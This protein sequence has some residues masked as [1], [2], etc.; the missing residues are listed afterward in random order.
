[1]LTTS[2]SSAIP[3]QRSLLPGIDVL[4][5]H[6]TFGAGETAVR[7]VDG[8][9]FT[10]EPGEVVALM[11]ASGCGKST[12][13]NIIA[14]LEQADSGKVTVH[15]QEVT[16]MSDKEK[17]ELRLSTVG[18]VFQEN[19]LIEDLTAAENVGL[20]L[21]AAGVPRA[22]I[23]GEVAGSRGLVGLDSLAGRFPREMSGGQ[24]Q[25]V[26]IARAITGGRSVLLADEPTGALDSANSQSVFE[27]LGQLAEA[28]LTVLVVTHD[29]LVAPHSTRTLYMRDGRL[30]DGPA[31]K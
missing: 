14:G 4:D 3:D 27:L 31:P 9:S 21:E 24:R 29:P 11:G 30:L 22:R 26:G 6:R 2:S 19:E 7:A 8:A 18:V 1:M 20:V 16:H 10:V 28:G 13:L 5:V 15:G 17:T 25:R 23:A 12:L